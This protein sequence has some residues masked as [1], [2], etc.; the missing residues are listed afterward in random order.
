MSPRVADPAIRDAL[1]ELGAQL[2]ADR[3]PLTTRR[4]AAGVG[5][6]TSA[7]YTHFGSMDELRSAIRKAGFE[8]LAAFLRRC[9]VSDDPVAD[10]AKQGWAYCHNAKVNP[11]MYR[12]MFM[13]PAAESDPGVGLYTFEMLVEGVQRAIDEGRFEDGD[14]QEMATRLWASAHGTVALYL[15]GL[16]DGDTVDR[17]TSEIARA[18]FLS[19]GDDPE[20]VDASFDKAGEWVLTQLQAQPGGTQA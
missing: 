18:L 11:N 19:F 12:A 1:V 3:E 4:L 7:V 8:R 14:A 5:T 17:L 20:R 9:D 15:A 13:E 10:L 16:F 2:I 6:S